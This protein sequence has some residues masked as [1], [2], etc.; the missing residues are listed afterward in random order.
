M[1]PQNNKE[2]NNIPVQE[3]VQ[4]IAEALVEYL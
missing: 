1:K 4:E 2:E 3:E